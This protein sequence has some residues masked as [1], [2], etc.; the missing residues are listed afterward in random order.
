MN[1]NYT[2]YKISLLNRFLLLFKKK[3]IIKT[4]EAI[5]VFKQLRGVYYIID[6]KKL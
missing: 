6:Y 4:E 5:L 2:Q 1:I 3:H